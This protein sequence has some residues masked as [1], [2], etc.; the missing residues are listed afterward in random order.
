MSESDCLSASQSVSSLAWPLMRPRYCARA[1]SLSLSLSISCVLC[2]SVFVSVSLS[3]SLC[4]CLSVCLSVS[5]S[6]TLSFSLSCSLIPRIAARA[7]SGLPKLASMREIHG[8]YRVSQQT[9]SRFP[10]NESC[11]QKMDLRRRD[12][13]WGTANHVEDPTESS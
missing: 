2:L 12:E 6:T 11:V 4:L 9:T 1:R 5:L 13:G 10:V 7:N 3:L 8:K